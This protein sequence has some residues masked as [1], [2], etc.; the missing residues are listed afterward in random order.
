[1]SW[2]KNIVLVTISFCFCYFLLIVGDWFIGRTMEQA[3]NRNLAYSEAAEVENQRVQSEDIPQRERAISE[4]FSPMIY[5]SLL[6]PIQQEYPLIAGLPFTDTYYCN[7][8]YGLIKYRSDRFGFRNEDSLWDKEPRKIMIGDS[9]VHGACV[10]D[11]STIPYLLSKEL[12][13][14]VMNLGIGG[15]DPSHYYAYAKL[16]VPLVKPTELYVVFYANDKGIEDKSAVEYAYVEEDKKIFDKSEISL[17]DVD[18]FKKEGER[19]TALLKKQ[20]EAKMQAS[21]ID[22]AY[23]AVIRHSKLPEISNIIFQKKSSFHMTRRTI[24]RVSGLCNDYECNVI[25]GFI[26][27]SEYFRPDSHADEYGNRI[28]KLTEQLGL[29][30]VDGRNLLDR[31]KNSLDYALKGPHLSPVGYKKMADAFANR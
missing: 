17:F 10:P 6:D 15:N 2:I 22:R 27:N 13:E 16:F 3:I 28:A 7:E 20:S 24:E 4:G 30:F 31:T 1:M 12:N 9:F 8:G 21:L 23:N 19:A 26:P 29:D 18:Y 11:E 25:V 5:P 14:T